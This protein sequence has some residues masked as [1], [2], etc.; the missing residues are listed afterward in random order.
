MTPGAEPAG[1][2]IAEGL[3][4]NELVLGYLRF[5]KTYYF[6]NG[7][8]TGKVANIKDAVK[9]LG[10]TRS[11]I[12]VEDFGPISL[13]AVRDNMVAD[14]LSRGVVNERLNRILR[15]FKWGVENQ[16]VHPS[17]LH[18]LQAVAALKRGRCNVR[19]TEQI[20]P[21]PDAFVDAVIKV[22]PTQIAAMIE[23]QRLTGMRPGKVVLM[24][25]C[26]IDTTGQIWQYPRSSTRPSTMA[27]VVYLGPQGV[28]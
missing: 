22:A 28:A 19:E 17:V 27:R 14:D 16:L 4:V 11:H 12:P 7:R 2:A 18:G 15:V 5:A 25:I 6:K 23:L 21:V 13:K 8:P 3:T 1:A 24:R 20:T 10:M 26:D 9:P